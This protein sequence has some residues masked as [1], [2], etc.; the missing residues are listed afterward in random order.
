[1]MPEVIISQAG[2]FVRFAYIHRNPLAV[3]K[4]LGPA[5]ITVDPTVISLRRNCGSD[6]KPSRN[7]NRARQ[8]DEIDV[9]IRAIARAGIAGI[10][11]VADAPAG[12]VSGVAQFFD[13]V[14]V[15]R[16]GSG[17]VAP[18]S[19]CGLLGNRAEVFVG[20]DEPFWIQISL[21]T[22][23]ANTV[24]RFFESLDVITYLNG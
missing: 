8:G 21:W 7:A 4:E 23:L 17:H 6:G 14:L 12:T 15:K 24:F 9:E 13:H 5:M 18:F 3:G 16:A 19:A 10:H 11:R 22:G 2:V 1:M 20:R